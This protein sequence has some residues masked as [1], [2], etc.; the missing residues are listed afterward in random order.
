MTDRQL[1]CMR[2][3]LYFNDGYCTITKSPNKSIKIGCRTKIGWW[4]VLVGAWLIFGESKKFRT[5]INPLWPE[6]PKEEQT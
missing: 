5:I 1:N 3:G 6:P 4:I 2:I